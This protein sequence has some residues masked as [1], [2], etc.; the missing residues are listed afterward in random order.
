MPK[1]CG[2]EEEDWE[3]TGW[4]QTVTGPGKAEEEFGLHPVGRNEPSEVL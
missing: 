1:Q 3:V 4:D 2:Y